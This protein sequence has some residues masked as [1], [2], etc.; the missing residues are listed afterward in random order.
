M[1]NASIVA[2]GTF[3]LTTSVLSSVAFTDSHCAT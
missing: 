2:C 3:V 1:S